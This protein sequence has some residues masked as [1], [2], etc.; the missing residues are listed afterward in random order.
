MRLEIASLLFFRLREPFSLDIRCIEIALDTMNNVKPII[1]QRALCTMQEH[2]RTGP[3]CL[4]ID[5]VEVSANLLSDKYSSKEN[6][7]EDEQQTRNEVDGKVTVDRTLTTENDFIFITIKCLSVGNNDE[8]TRRYSNCD[9]AYANRFSENAG[10]VKVLKKGGLRV[11]KETIDEPGFTYKAIEN[12]CLAKCKYS[13][14]RSYVNIITSAGSSVLQYQTY[15]VNVFFAAPFSPNGKNIIR[16]G[17]IK[18]NL[19]QALICLIGTRCLDSGIESL[20]IAS[21]VDSGQEFTHG[22]AVRAKVAR[23]KQTDFSCTR[24]TSVSDIDVY[25][26]KAGLY[27]LLKDKAY[28]GRSLLTYS[29]NVGESENATVYHISK[30]G[31]D[32]PISVSCF[33]AELLCEMK[34][35]MFYV[36]RNEETGDFLIGR[37]IMDGALT[38]ET[39]FTVTETHTPVKT[40]KLR[41]LTMA[42][43]RRKELV[44]ACA[45]DGDASRLAIIVPMKETVEMLEITTQTLN[46]IKGK[47]LIWKWILMETYCAYLRTLMGKYGALSQSMQCHKTMDKYTGYLRGESLS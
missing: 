6:E 32:I 30:D 13:K 27:C 25:N 35:G 34:G 26:D 15:M 28:S 43:S 5:R 20:F 7:E 24:R 8:Y 21:D 17:D 3:N 4:F 10:R 47:L 2:S 22:V 46:T 19:S 33:K 37:L 29:T 12:K 1:R 14:K 16:I 36:S 45:V 44:V 9:N 40:D 23:F 39:I 31:P 38:K 18:K 11:D 42:E 41:P